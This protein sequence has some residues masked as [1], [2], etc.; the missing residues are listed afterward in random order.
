MC[1]SPVR[2]FLQVRK[3]ELTFNH[4]DRRDV[5]S[6][7]KFLQSPNILMMPAQTY[8]RKRNHNAQRNS[9][10]FNLIAREKTLHNHLTY[11]AMR[12][13]NFFTYLQ[14]DRTIHKQINMIKEWKLE[15]Y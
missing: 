9:E 7:D 6:L 5:L 11:R 3:R 10:Q 1:K 15:H 12:K 13:F 8:S 4:V 2:S 14:I